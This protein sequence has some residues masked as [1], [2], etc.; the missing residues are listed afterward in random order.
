[1]SKKFKT[2]WKRVTS[3]IQD[4]TNFEFRVKIATKQWTPE[5]LADADEIEFYPQAK[6]EAIEQRN[7][8]L[9]N[10]STVEDKFLNPVDEEQL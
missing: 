10:A 7:K 5:K 3:N 9:L 2:Q 8:R 4:E 6:R 1:M